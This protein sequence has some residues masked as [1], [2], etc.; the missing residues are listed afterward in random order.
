MDVEGD[1]VMV[2][3][4]HKHLDLEEIQY[5][6]TAGTAPEPITE[7][8]VSTWDRQPN[9]LNSYI[10]CHHLLPATDRQHLTTNA[11]T[12]RLSE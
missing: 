8:Q 1:N 2:G 12:P 3:A 5:I 11:T 9:G 10:K 7:V 6:R 4:P